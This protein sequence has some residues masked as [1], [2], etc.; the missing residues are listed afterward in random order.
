MYSYEIPMWYSKI[1][2]YSILLHNCG[3]IMEIKSNSKQLM[4]K[5]EDILVI[6]DDECLSSG[7]EN[8]PI[9]IWENLQMHWPKNFSNLY[10]S[11]KGRDIC[12]D[13][14]IFS[15][16]IKHNKGTLETELKNKNNTSDITNY[17]EKSDE[18]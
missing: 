16:Y 12:E 4:V 1:I 11:T 6:T 13:F 10:I 2:I 18:T 5:L 9:Y 15:N 17:V 3:W 7:Q 8:L 14:M